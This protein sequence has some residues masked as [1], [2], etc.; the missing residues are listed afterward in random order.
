MYNLTLV[1]VSLNRIKELRTAAEMKQS[2]LAVLLSTTNTA[3]SKYELGQRDLSSEMICRLCEIFDCTADYLLGRSEIKTTELSEQET[4]VLM[5]YRKAD[6]HVKDLVRLALDPYWEK[7]R[8]EKA[9]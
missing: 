5:A 4:S 6:D 2:D 8:S 7:G 3:I 1:V 9:I